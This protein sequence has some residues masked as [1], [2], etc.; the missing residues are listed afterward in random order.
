M[1]RPKRKCAFCDAS[2][3]SKGEHLWDNWLNKELPKKTRFNAQKRL[4]LDAVPIRF[5][6]VGLKEQVPVVCAKCNGGW[7]SALSAKVKERF[8]ESALEAKPFSLDTRDAALLA[9][10]TFLKA[11]VKDYCYGK[12]PFFTS[13]DRERLRT[14]LTVPP[15]TKVWFAAHAGAARYTFHSNINIVSASAP[16]PLQGMEFFCY[17]YIVGRLV[18]QLLSPRWENVLDRVKPLVSLNPHPRWEPAASLFW[19]YRRAVLPCSWPPNSYF[20]DDTIE[21]FFYRFHVPVKMPI[22]FPY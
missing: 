2:A 15:L 8:S 4:T 6:T 12:E 5:E 11:S 7:M 10:Y 13:A 20:G 1:V 22:T 17:T 18:L 14:S 9:A 19:P 16:G 3:T 21:Q